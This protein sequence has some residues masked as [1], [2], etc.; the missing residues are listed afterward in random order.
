M[1]THARTWACLFL[2]TH[3]AL[4]CSSSPR[5]DERSRSEGA[6]TTTTISP[7]LA[8]VL[9]GGEFF[10]TQHGRDYR[11]QGDITLAVQPASRSGERWRSATTLSG[12][13]GSK[14]YPNTDGPLTLMTTP[15]DDIAGGRPVNYGDIGNGYYCGGAGGNGNYECG[16]DRT[17]HV[18]FFIDR[19]SLRCEVT[20][21]EPDMNS[22]N[23]TTY[24]VTSTTARL[25]NC[26]DEAYYLAHNPDVADAVAS[27]AF[28][29][30]RQHFDANGRNEGRAGC[31]CEFDETFYL[32]NNP[33]VAA[34]VSTGVFLTGRH[35]YALHGRSEGRAACPTDLSPSQ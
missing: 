16:P 35:H 32:S 8:D 11:N 6:L 33:D 25:S 26:F 10:C 5:G 27:G 1:I 2:L 7:L 31:E 22:A 14:P 3:G 29:S 20:A 34:A 12:I 13:I 17:D 21:E 15:S 19:G 23:G 24:S 30:A 4:G 9:S 28:S 18:R